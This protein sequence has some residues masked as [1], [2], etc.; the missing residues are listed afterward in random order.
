MSPPRNRELRARARAHY[1]ELARVGKALSSPVR[2]L[3]LDLLRQGPRSVDALAEQCG[4]SVANVS[5]HLQQLR[6]AHLVRS[7]RHAQRIVYE[8]S[9]ESVSELFASVR[10]VSEGILPDMLPLQKAFAILS[11]TQREAVFHKLESKHAL[12][13]DVRPLAEFDAGHLPGAKSIP[14]DELQ[15]RLAELPAREIIAYCRG[16]YCSMALEAVSILEAAGFR[17]AHLDLGPPDLSARGVALE[18]QPESEERTES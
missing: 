5:Q 12:L 8:I 7:E 6:T 2:L 14:L 1:E 4:E 17:A 18:T 13:L 3:L 9:D 10:R 16:P 15:G 11:D